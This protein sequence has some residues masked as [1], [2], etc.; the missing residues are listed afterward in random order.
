M[1][2][3]HVLYIV[4]APGCLGAISSMSVNTIAAN[5]FMYICDEGECVY[6]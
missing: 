2:K 3:A 6:L 5:V 1:W 4:V